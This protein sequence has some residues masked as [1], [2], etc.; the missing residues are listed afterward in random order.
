MGQ[1]FIFRLNQ[2][3]ISDTMAPHTD[4]D[5]VYF[6]LK[7]GN[8]IFPATGPIA[9]KIGD[10]NN[11]TYV[12]NW[13][14]GPINIEPLDQ[15]AMT[16]QIVN[17]GHDDD[18]KQ[19]QNAIAI[20]TKIAEGLGTVVGAVFPSTAEVVGKIVSALKT[21]GGD[22][23]WLFGQLNCDGA[24]LVDAFTSNGT[25]LVSLT[26]TGHFYQIRNYTGPDTPFWS[27]CGG[28]AHYAVT[29]SI[30]WPDKAKESKEDKDNEKDKERKEGKEFPKEGRGKEQEDITQPAQRSAVSPHPPTPFDAKFDPRFF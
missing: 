16:Y 24:V 3:E 26:Q 22:L 30:I 15:V 4:T 13:D 2:F 1:R 10:L 17:N 27:F 5:W 19:K 29:W 8:Q 20:A 12:L 7:V 14:I 25:D 18:T 21:L 9:Q 28:N 6:S 23:S 11:G